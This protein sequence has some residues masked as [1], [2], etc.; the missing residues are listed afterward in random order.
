MPRRP[1]PSGRRLTVVTVAVIVLIGATMAYGQRIWVG[2][3]SGGY[4]RY[5]PKWAKAGDFDGSFIYCRGFYTSA[6]RE[7]S[8]SGWNTDYP[9]ADNNFPIR[10]SELTRVRVKFDPDRQPHHVVVSL[11]DPLLFRCGI[12]FMEDV[13]TAELSEEEV[14][15]LREYLLKGGFLWVDDSWGSR[16]WESWVAQISRV[17]PP[18][19]FPLFDVPVTHP[20][21]RTVYDVKEIPQVPA[22][23][24]WRRSRGR[25]S[26]RG[27]DSTQVYVK[28]IQ[29][30]RGRLMVLMTHNTD[31][32]DTWEREGEEPRDYFD[33]FSPRG[34]AIGVNVVLY[35]MTH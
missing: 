12:L 17:M 21:M 35:A 10:L 31:I 26:E 23:S 15:R 8:G 14:F 11:T 34:Y 13:G 4:G 25:T 24:F 7:Q 6:W 27:F 16:A 19:E 18:S 3:W 2:G 5:P 29:D 9:G 1:F 32:A 33:T 22:I 30:S 20:M 28:G